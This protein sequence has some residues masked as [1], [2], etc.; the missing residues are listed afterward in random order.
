MIALCFNDQETTRNN[1]SVLRNKSGGWSLPS[2]WNHAFQNPEIQKCPYDF[3]RPPDRRNHIK[4]TKV[5]ILKGCEVI[6]KYFLPEKQ[7]NI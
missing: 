1:Q 4:N 7:T 6:I 5:D 3:H 2:V